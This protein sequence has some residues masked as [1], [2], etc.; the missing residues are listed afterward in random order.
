[1]IQHISLKKTSV[2]EPFPIVPSS[3][4][5]LAKRDSSMEQES[6]LSTNP[7]ENNVGCIH[8]QLQG[9]Y[10]PF[11]PNIWHGNFS[12]SLFITAQQNSLGFLNVVLAVGL[13]FELL[14]IPEAVSL[15]TS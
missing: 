13:R 1:M 2:I 12:E 8:K 11:G 9:K 5:P 6:V 14:C 4:V 15:Q 3:R 7:P 10:T